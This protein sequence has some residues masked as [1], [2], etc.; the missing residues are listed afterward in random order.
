M[1]ETQKLIVTVAVFALITLGLAQCVVRDVDDDVVFGGRSGDVALG[2]CGGG[3]GGDEGR[4][5]ADHGGTRQRTGER[6][7]RLLQVSAARSQQLSARVPF[8]A[9]N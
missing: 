3:H 2:G 7:M 5:T 9:L 1:K 4:D 6:E 8:P